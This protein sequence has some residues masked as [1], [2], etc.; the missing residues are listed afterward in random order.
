VGSPEL[1]GQPLAARMAAAHAGAGVTG[2][3]SVE[4]MFAKVE[5]HLAQHPE[6]GRGWE[7]IAPVYTRLGRYED[8]ARARRNAIRALGSTATRQSDLG[9]ALAMAANGVVT[10]EA[11]A[12]FDEAIRIDP[13]DVSARYY[14]GLASEQD[15]NV[16]EAARLWRSLLA[17]AP[18]GA[19]WVPFVR[20]ALARVD[21]SAAPAAPPAAGG[22]SQVDMIRGMVERLAARLHRDGSDPDGWVRL[23]RSYRVLQEP[24]RAAAAAA[25]A[26]SALAAEPDKLRRFE[27]GLRELDA[28]AGATEAAPATPQGPAPSPPAQTGA[29]TDDA[30]IRQMVERL[31]TRLHQD[32]SDVDGWVRLVRSYSVLGDRERM[33]GAIDDAHSALSGDPEKRRRFD[34]GVKALGIEG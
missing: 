26:R 25:D 16:A 30:M 3:E 10:A 4:A 5:A 22:A 8:A 33:R 31:A 15:G 12:A 19:Q 24:E 28:A 11:K 21:P 7:V 17:D 13:T 18:Q 27:D 6:D 20:T 34:D 32:G 14:E 29:D 9:E 2:R 1:P 23:V